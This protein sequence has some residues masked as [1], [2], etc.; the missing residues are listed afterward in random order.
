MKKRKNAQWLGLLIWGLM[1]AAVGMTYA[2]A[3]TW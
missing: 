2:R 3:R 1:G